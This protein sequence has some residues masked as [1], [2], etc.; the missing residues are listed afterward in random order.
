[1]GYTSKQVCE[2]VGC[3]Y[4]QLDYWLTR[5]WIECSDPNPGSGQMRSFSEVQLGRVRYVM[6]TRESIRQQ[7]READVGSFAGRYP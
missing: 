3:T 2:M 6:E 1:M 4:R 7:V 5:G